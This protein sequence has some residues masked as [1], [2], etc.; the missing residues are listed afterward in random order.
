MRRPAALDFR[1]LR[2][3]AQRN[4]VP[5]YLWD[6]YVPEQLLWF[7]NQQLARTDELWGSVTDYEKEQ[8]RLRV[9]RERIAR[10]EREKAERMERERVQKIEA[11][12]RKARAAEWKKYESGIVNDGVEDDTW[13][14]VK[15]MFS[16]GYDS[17]EVEVDESE[18][19]GLTARK[20]SGIALGMSLDEDGNDRMVVGQ[21]NSA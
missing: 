6:E 13:Y 7:D 21:V 14:A 3:T 11:A 17:M 15:D 19:D 12:R 4:A 8:E 9:E 20:D 18:Y 2:R 1:V 10:E 16:S 5:P